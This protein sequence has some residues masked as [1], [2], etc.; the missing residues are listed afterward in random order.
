MGK[1]QLLFSLGVTVALTGDISIAQVLPASLM[2]T[3]VRG[4][5]RSALMGQPR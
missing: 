2:C 3:V 1:E 4:L 5:L